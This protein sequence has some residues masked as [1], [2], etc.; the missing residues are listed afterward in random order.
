MSRCDRIARRRTR[1]NTTKDERGKSMLRPQKDETF[2]QVLL[3]V[4]RLK[5]KE[6]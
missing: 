2:T 5:K 1:W 4:L 6:G 3:R